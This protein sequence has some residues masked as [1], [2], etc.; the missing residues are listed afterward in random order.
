MILYIII[1]ILVL[2]VLL[3]QGFLKALIVINFPFVHI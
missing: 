1:I 2:N 3:Q